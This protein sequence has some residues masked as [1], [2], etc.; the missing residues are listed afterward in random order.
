[1]MGAIVSGLRWYGRPP[2]F[3]KADRGAWVAG[4]GATGEALRAVTARLPGQHWLLFAEINGEFTNHHPDPTEEK[5]LAALIDTVKAEGAEI[6]IAFDG[7]GDR[8]GVVDSQG[9]IIRGDQLMQILAADVLERHPGAQIIADVKAS[10]ALFDEIESL[11]GR[12][13]MWNTGHSLIKA[14]MAKL[15]APLAGEMSGHIFYA[16]GF[17][18]HDDALYVAIRLLGILAKS[19]ETLAEKHDR[20]PRPVNT[21]EIRI[22]CPDERK[23]EVVDRVR[24]KLETE[25]AR[26]I[27][28]DGVRVT[29][30]D[31]WWLLRASNTQ[32]VLVVRA[33]A[34]DEA[35]LERLK[36]Q[37]TPASG[38]IR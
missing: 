38:K 16:D 27:T 8:I 17:Y 13:I 5:N 12:P 6:G 37:L 32:A 3:A 7:D 26:I 2:E 24:V 21:P 18:G 1:V 33:E 9:R 35:G 31:G 23:F 22:P 34:K 11:G 15:G 30:E 10:Q 19:P 28:I 20:M 25:G 36:Q 29:T 14:Q 4:N